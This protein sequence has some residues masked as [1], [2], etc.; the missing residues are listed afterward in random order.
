M[1]L[2]RSLVQDAEA[3]VRNVSQAV[4]A[5]EEVIRLS[6][7]SLLAG[8]HLLINDMPGVGKTLVARSIAGSIEGSFKRIQFTPDLLPTD[9]TGAS[10]FNQAENRFEFL[11][12]PIFAN[13]V[14]ADEI[15][16]A[17]TRTQSALLEAMAE[18][19]I[20][21]EGHAYAL[22]QPFWVVATQNEIDGYGTFPLPQAQLDRFM[23]SLNIGYPTVDQQVDILQRNAHGDPDVSPIIPTDGIHRMQAE[24]RDIEV[25]QPLR[26]YIAR[27]VSATQ[28]HP[29]LAIGVSPRGAVQLQRASQAVAAME[30]QQFV[31]PHHIKTVA[32][33]VLAHRLLPSATTTVSSEDTIRDIL[34]NLPVPH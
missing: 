26:E 28:N 2:T 17:S 29:H 32:I 13:I 27:L 8:G 22:P 12:G 11:P 23:V 30:G 10:I 15:N 3:L 5:R 19:Q 14:L 21:A 33:P 34:S 16:R 6:I 25:A 9:I 1:L 7:V 24:V 20:T 4:V 18:S 31:A